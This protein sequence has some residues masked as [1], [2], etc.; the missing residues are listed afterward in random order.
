VELD[1]KENRINEKKARRPKKWELRI[2]R[3]IGAVDELNQR[4]LD[5]GLK[6]DVVDTDALAS[7]YLAQEQEKEPELDL[8]SGAVKGAAARLNQGDK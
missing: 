7:Q 8:L 4:M 3:M 1:E 6:D 2:R 5:I